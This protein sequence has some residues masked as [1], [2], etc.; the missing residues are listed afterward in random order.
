MIKKGEEF[1]AIIIE[2]KVLTKDSDYFIAIAFNDI[3][4]YK[5]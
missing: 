5:S 1:A 3:K 4:D 2:P